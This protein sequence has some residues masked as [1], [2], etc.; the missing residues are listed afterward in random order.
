MPT[1]RSG[2][3]SEPSPTA[4]AAN[5]WVSP[6]TL[7]VGTTVGTPANTTV[8]PG[9]TFASLEF[10]VTTLFRASLDSPLMLAR[11]CDGCINSMDLLS[12]S[13]AEL[14]ELK[15]NAPILDA[16]G[17]DTGQTQLTQLGQPHCGTLWALL[18][19]A[20]LC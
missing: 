7:T 10:A 2:T 4:G 3:N 9:D 5:Q 15:Y 20:Y 6:A 12:Y 17:V 13:E 16:Q 14:L 18:G 8:Q 1:T 11:C 19:Y